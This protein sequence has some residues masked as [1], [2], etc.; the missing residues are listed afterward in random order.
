M[1]L[2]STYFYVEA[3]TTV[4]D[5]FCLKL[6]ENFNSFHISNIVSFT[7]LQS[8][9]TSLPI[10]YH[11]R[12]LSLE[13]YV[14]CINFS[15]NGKFFVPQNQLLRYSCNIVTS[16]HLLFSKALINQF[17]ECV[18]KLFHHHEFFQ[19]HLIVI[20]IRNEGFVWLH[21]TCIWNIK[22]LLL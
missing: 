22:T 16:A 21:S 3:F 15:I 9:S 2:G 1:F 7:S 13:F 20:L 14:H 12:V 19:F 6:S 18:G 8:S 5:T 11:I 4:F 17:R 10:T